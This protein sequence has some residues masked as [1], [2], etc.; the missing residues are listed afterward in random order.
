MKR[1]KRI[2]A[3]FSKILFQTNYQ[4]I[5]GNETEELYDKFEEHVKK[6]A[7][8]FGLNPEEVRVDGELIG[9]ECDAHWKSETKIL[10][11]IY[12]SKQ[13]LHYEFK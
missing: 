7:I 1:S 4:D 3:E 5:C 8:E 6:K 12:K 13:I 10:K 11:I 2:L 9:F